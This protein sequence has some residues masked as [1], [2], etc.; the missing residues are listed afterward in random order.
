[1]MERSRPAVKDFEDLIE[2]VREQTEIMQVI[3]QRIILDR[4]HKALCPFHEEKTPSFSVNLKV[5]IDHRIRKG[6]AGVDG[7]QRPGYFRHTLLTSSKGYDCSCFIWGQRLIAPLLI[8]RF[9]GML[10]RM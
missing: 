10:L 5:G 8:A 2:R 7:H 9:K 4:H 6:A 3:G 1:M